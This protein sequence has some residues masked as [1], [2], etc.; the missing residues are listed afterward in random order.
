[1]KT[2]KLISIQ[3]LIDDKIIPIELVD[4]LIIN[5]EDDH[6]HWLIDIYSNHS[7]VD[8]FQ[9]INEEKK[10]MLVH[11]VITKKENDPAP[12]EVEVRSIQIF[13]HTVSILLEGTLKRNRKDYAEMLLDYLLEEGYTGEELSSE[14]KKLMQSNPQAFL[15]KNA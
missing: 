11:A 7:S 3:V 1:M 13:E 9:K 5:K 15:D 2:F 10:D 8:L 12:F 4:G 14:F 6:N